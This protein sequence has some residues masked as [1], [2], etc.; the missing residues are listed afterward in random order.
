MITEWIATSLSLIGVLLISRK[1]VEGFYFWLV[2]NALWAY[3]GVISK[4]WGMAVL[5]IV[6][7]G[8]S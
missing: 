2:A 8:T 7:F 6:Y 3:I 1:R 4:L 5:F